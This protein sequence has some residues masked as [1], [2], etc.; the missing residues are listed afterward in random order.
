MRIKLLPALA[1]SML[2]PRFKRIQPRQGLFFRG[3]G[4]HRVSLAF[5]YR[6]NDQGWREY[7]LLDV[8][9]V[10][11]CSMAE[12]P[13]GS[14]LRVQANELGTRCNGRQ[15]ISAVLRPRQSGYHAKTFGVPP[16]REA[17]T[18]TP[19]VTQ[20]TAPDSPIYAQLRV[21]IRAGPLVA[22]R[23]TVVNAGEVPLALDS[24]LL[25]SLAVRGGY[26]VSTEF[27]RA[28]TGIRVKA[29][30]SPDRRHLI[31]RSHAQRWL[32]IRQFTYPRTA[33]HFLTA[34]GW[35]PSAKHWVT[36]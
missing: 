20:D 23:R 27:W 1:L 21:W 13:L 14:G 2:P 28:T 31:P 30:V 10:S 35:R 36:G 5:H 15:I 18:R 9:W 4:D 25:G 33:R 34:P 32:S 7:R 11:P 8:H 17:G 12:M 19:T 16:R 22:E 26:Q 3:R 24:D 29:G 6:P